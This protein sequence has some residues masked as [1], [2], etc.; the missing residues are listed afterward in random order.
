[1]P[2]DDKADKPTS[3]FSR[4][5]FLRGTAAGAALSGGLLAGEEAQ[6]AAQSTTQVAGPGAVPI[7]LQVNG[8]SH[9]LELEPRV[10]LLD[11]LRNHLNL[12]GS[13]K[14]CDRGTCGA[15]TVLMDGKAVYACSV[16]AIEA[17]GK[18]IETIESLGNRR[19]AAPD[20]GGFC[21]T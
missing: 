2:K 13:K 11:A 6:A 5:D 7:T 15:C 20:P 17:Q 10:T 16:L 1:M 8:K 14:V 12:T 19:Q 9:R 4:R 18:R 3:G 21:G